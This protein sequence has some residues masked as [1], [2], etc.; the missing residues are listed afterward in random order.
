MKNPPIPGGAAAEIVRLHGE[1]LDAYRGSIEKGFRIGELLTEQKAKLDH[2]EWLTWLEEN[3][4]FTDRTARNY[5]R[6]YD[7]RDRF[8]EENIAAL[9]AAYRLLTESEKPTK[10]ETSFRSEPVAAAPAV[11]QN[12][13]ADP[14]PP[15]AEP[16]LVTT[17]KAAPWSLAR[18][19]DTALDCIDALILECPAGRRKEL[20]A[21]IVARVAHR[22]T[23]IAPAPPAPRPRVPLIDALAEIE[24]IP[25]DGITKSVGGRLAD[26]LREI[27]EAEPDVTPNDIRQHAANYPLH[28]PK[29]GLTANA[30]AKWWGKTGKP[31]Q[32]DAKPERVTD[33]TRI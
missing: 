8:K 2:G 29:A 17:E 32:S 5:A 19:I 4:P 31:P 22:Y 14:P 13:T 7:Q 15:E 25:L 16:E 30:L 6:L 10:S 12:A 27:H 26:A 3:V 23:P 28:F 20:Q 24:G 11:A 33:N 18:A 21:A 9:G 1:I